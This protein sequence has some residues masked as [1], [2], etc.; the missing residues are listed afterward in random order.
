MHRITETHRDAATH[1]VVARNQSG[2]L[3]LVSFHDDVFQAYR[4]R[5]EVLKSM[6]I[7]HA[8]VRRMS[9]HSADWIEQLVL[10]C[11]EVLL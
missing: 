5:N 3:G 9:Q 2:K 4:R 10:D 1:F 8:E 11:H 6:G 7:V